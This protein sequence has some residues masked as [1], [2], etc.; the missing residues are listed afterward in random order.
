MKKM[1][2]MIIVFSCFYMNVFSQNRL[3]TWDLSAISSIQIDIQTE[4]S[5][6]DV[7][8]YNDQEDID[9]IMSFLLKVDFHAYNSNED[10][11]KIKGDWQFR[12]T[13][14]GQR[15][16]IYLFNDYAFIGKSIYMIDDIV[17]KDFKDLIGLI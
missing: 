9:K 5:K 13:F 4:D 10:S 15:D 17:V 8:L 2:F 1:V 11:G 6:I 12:L 3:H 14:K 7:K 16:Q